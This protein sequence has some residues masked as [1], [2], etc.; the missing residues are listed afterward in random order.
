MKRDAKWNFIAPS[1]RGYQRPLVL[2]HTSPDVGQKALMNCN[3]RIRW[4]KIGLS[5]L[6]LE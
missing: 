4:H 2:F 1:E 5:S 3:G 6:N